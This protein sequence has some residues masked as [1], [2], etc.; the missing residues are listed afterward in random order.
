[1]QNTFLTPTQFRHRQLEQLPKKYGS[2]YALFDKNVSPE[3]SAR[4]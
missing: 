3:K 2:S 1:M 4:K